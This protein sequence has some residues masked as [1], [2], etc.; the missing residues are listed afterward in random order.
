MQ[1]TL[2]NK[3][4]ILSYRNQRRLHIRRKQVLQLSAPHREYSVAGFHTERS[5]YRATGETSTVAVDGAAPMA[6]ALN[7]LL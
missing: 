3:L 6:G 1:G 7:L 5:G 4:N 2:A